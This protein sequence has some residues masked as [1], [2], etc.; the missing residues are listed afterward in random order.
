MRRRIPPSPPLPHFEPKS[1]DSSLRR[2]IEGLY[3]PVSPQIGSQSGHISM[4][5]TQLKRR[6][7]HCRIVVPKDVRAAFDDPVEFT[8]SPGTTSECGAQRL[9][10]PYVAEW[11]RQI[12]DPSP[13]AE[14]NAPEGCW[15]HE[16]A[17]PGVIPIP[18][19]SGHS[20][21]ILL[22]DRALRSSNNSSSSLAPEA[23]GSI[24]R[25]EP[26]AKNTTACPS[27]L[28]RTCWTSSNFRCSVTEPLVNDRL[29]PR[30]RTLRR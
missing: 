1:L 7:W 14:S 15:R 24:R 20:G 18:A 19:E 28:T 16:I 17:A 9:A 29:V 21:D 13:A 6:S 10:A 2:A 11:S 25:N 26:S 22:S 23:C 5:C 30:H 12:S 8:K 3:S 27:R 4:S